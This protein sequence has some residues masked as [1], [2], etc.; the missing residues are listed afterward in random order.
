M[1][2]KIKTLIIF[3][4]LGLAFTNLSLAQP[5]HI[6][7]TI[8]GAKEMGEQAVEIGK[9]ELPG[10]IEKIWKEDVLPVWQI[11]YDWFELNI[12][13]KIKSFF[14]EEIKPRFQQ[15]V[16]KRKPIIKEEFE[17]EKEELKEELPEVSKSLWQRLKDLWE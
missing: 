15:E 12:W 2:K 6:P 4:I 7:D 5:L 8:E 10:T 13:F 14:Q 11:M 16:E 1:I 9:Q 3:L 17:K